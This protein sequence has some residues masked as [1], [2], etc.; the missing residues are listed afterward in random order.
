MAT[1]LSSGP[2][3]WVRATAVPT[4]IVKRA[5]SAVNR[6]ARNFTPM[7]TSLLTV[8][9]E[10]EEIEISQYVIFHQDTSLIFLSEATIALV[11]HRPYKLPV[12]T[13]IA[14]QNGE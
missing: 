13:L 5:S 10:R 1:V 2:A 6:T 14:A 3:D 11:L 7:L 8:A 12:V 9:R 4:R